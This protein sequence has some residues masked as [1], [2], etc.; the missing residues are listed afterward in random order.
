MH[1]YY[2]STLQG[3]PLIS[4]EWDRK[5]I[6]Q[7]IAEVSDTVRMIEDKQFDGEVQNTYACRF[8]DMRYVCGK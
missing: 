7:A 3:D 8:C 6:D 1:L 5:A 4:F 2:T